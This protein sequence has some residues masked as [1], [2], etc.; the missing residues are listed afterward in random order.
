MDKKQ[1]GNRPSLAR[2]MKNY[3]FPLWKAFLLLIFFS[4]LST[5]MMAVQ[6]IFLS[7]LIEIITG[8]R[9]DVTPNTKDTTSLSFF[10]LNTVGEKVNTF[11][12]DN[13]I[14]S[15]ENV[16]QSVFLILAL[17][18]CLALLSSLFNY[19]SQVVT[20]WLRSSSTG[21]IRKDVANHLL[22]LDLDFFHSQKSGELISRFTQDAT[23]TAIGLGPLLHGLIH[24]GILIIIYSAYLFS[25]DYVL[26]AGVIVV[27]LMQW[28]VTKAVKNPV[29]V[30]ERATL[31]RTANV[32]STLQEMLVSIR[33]IKSFGADQYEYK[34][35][36]KD[37]ERARRAEY[38]AGSVKS[39]EPNL[40]LFLDNFAIAAIFALG[41]FQLQ[42]NTLSLEGFLLFLFVGRLLITPINKFSVNFVWMH[43]LLA[44]YERLFEVFQI[45]NSI[46]DGDL[47]INDFRKSILVKNINFSHGNTKILNNISF[48]LKKGEKLAIVGSSG[49][50]KST[51][52]D[53]LLRFYDPDKGSIVIDNNDLKLYKINSY[54]NLFGVVPQESLLFN[55]SIIN[56]ICFGRGECDL[57]QVKHVA[58]ISNAHDFIMSLPEQYETIVGDRGVRLSGGQRQRISI[59]R[60]I[61]FNPKILLLDEATSALDSHSEQKVHLAID[62]ILNNSTAII[63]AHRLST[64]LHADK[65]MVLNNGSIEAIGKHQELL[66]T[67]SIYRELHDLQFNLKDEKR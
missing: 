11:L 56:N 49:S 59:A 46:K 34:K 29:R 47:I 17:F 45:K 7:G 8:E 33:V 55:D 57:S 32:V 44:S 63:V 25:T 28:I 20:S 3:A 22:S 43:S 67:C 6:P 26:A 38:R 24:H 14:P 12:F 37:I 53:L 27:G 35:I 13:S 21:L 51:L 31:D 19:L 36:S 39:I 9:A 58:K 23:N 30:T 66:D 40:R 54:R 60:A 41:V 42:N 2:L 64:I 48:E 1:S 52:T 5:I 10:N 50:G 4:F 15:N 16:L 65:I 62:K 61:Y 18:L